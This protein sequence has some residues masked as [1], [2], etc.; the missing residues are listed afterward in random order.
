MPAFL[1][2]VNSRSVRASQSNSHS[3][4]QPQER[5]LEGYQPQIIEDANCNKQPDTG[6]RVFICSNT[7]CSTSDPEDGESNQIQPSQG[8]PEALL[9]TNPDGDWQ[10]QGEIDDDKNGKL[11]MWGERHLPIAVFKATGLQ[12]RISTLRG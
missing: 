2:L 1:Q 12:G 4:Y 11:L 6:A 9:L 7:T 8:T 3:L 10:R 5:E